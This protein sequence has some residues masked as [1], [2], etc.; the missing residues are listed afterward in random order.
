MTYAEQLQHPLWQKKRLH[1]FERDKFTCTYCGDTDTQLHVHHKEYEN[2]KKA[3]EVPDELLI[4]LCKHCH[5]IVEFCKK[6]YDMAIIKSYWVTKNKGEKAYLISA[7]HDKQC[8]VWE[9]SDAGDLNGKQLM[10]AFPIYIMEDILK[11]L[12]EPN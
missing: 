10:T 11:F 8:F 3:W 2:G 12:K 9:L 7:T 5:D 6:N 1:I 4:T